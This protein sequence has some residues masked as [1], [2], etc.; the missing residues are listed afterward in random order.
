M[1]PEIVYV[2]FR[3]TISWLRATGANSKIAQKAIIPLKGIVP[4]NRLAVGQGPFPQ[5]VT[6]PSHGF[7]CIGNPVP[8]FSR[9]LL[10]RTVIHSTYNLMLILVLAPFR[11]FVPFGEFRRLLAVL[12]IDLDE[13]LV[14]LVLRTDLARGI[15]PVYSKT[16]VSR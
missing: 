4:T 6:T 8:R 3:T 16:A 2:F 12:L 9:N 13:H 1:L 7:P 10:C 11:G 5:A 14:L 15:A